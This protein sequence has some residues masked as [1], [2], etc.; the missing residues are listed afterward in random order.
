MAHRHMN[1]EIGTAATLFPEKE[2]ISGIFLAVSTRQVNQFLIKTYFSRRVRSKIRR[3]KDPQ[4]SGRTVQYVPDGQLSTVSQD[5]RF[6]LCMGCRS[7]YFPASRL[8]SALPVACAFQLAYLHAFLP[9]ICLRLPCLIILYYRPTRA[10][11]AE[12]TSLVLALQAQQAAIHLSFN[13]QLGH[14]SILQSFFL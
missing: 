13:S 1:V 4:F 2:Y 7:M 12:Q 3:T 9:V 11:K 8:P 6:S 10:A 5:T 14:L